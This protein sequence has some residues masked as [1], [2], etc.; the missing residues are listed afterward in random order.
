MTSTQ[1]RKPH[2]KCNTLPSGPWVPCTHG[3]H[4]SSTCLR[5]AGLGAPVLL[6]IPAEHAASSFA[7]SGGSWLAHTGPLGTGLG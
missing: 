2:R 6:V 1:D 7:L 3:D 5:R 4:D